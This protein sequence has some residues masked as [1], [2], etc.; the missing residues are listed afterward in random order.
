MRLSFLLT[1]AVLLLAVS[2]GSASWLEVEHADKSDKDT[3]R[4]FVGKPIKGRVGGFYFSCVSNTW[5]EAYVGLNY[6]PTSGLEFGIGYGVETAGD[7][8]RIGSYAVYS[9]DRLTLRYAYE[10]GGSGEYYKAGID[11]RATPKL[12]LG[13]VD[14]KFFG[15]GTKLDYRLSNEVT[16]RLTIYPEEAFVSMVFA[17]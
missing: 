6:T 1:V 12:T 14:H 5:S 9:K 13:V 16:S 10:N 2:T 17:F 4:L 7:H 8:R 3:F 11:Y 15:T